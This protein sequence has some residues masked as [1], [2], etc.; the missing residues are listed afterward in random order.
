[1][2]EEVRAYSWTPSLAQERRRKPWLNI[3]LFGI[4][5]VTTTLAGALQNGAN[6]LADPLQIV[7]GLPFALTLM[8]I[9]LVHEM[10]H[11]LMARHHGVDATLP[12][13]IPAPSFIGTFGAFIKLK[14]PPLDRRSL[15]D[16]GAA[17]PLAGLVLAIPAVIIGL[18]L[19]TVSI[20]SGMGG[21]ITLG[22]SILLDFLSRLTLGLLPDEANI[23]MHPI[24][25]AGWIGLFIT[26]LNLIPV[27]QLDGGHV[28]YALF[29]QRHVWVSRLSLVA[30]LALGLIRYW[31]GWLIWSVLL[32]FMGVRHPPTLDP[33][34]PL[35]LKRKLVGWFVVGVFF[36]TFIPAPFS[37]HQSKLP[38]EQIMPKPAKSPLETLE[39]KAGQ[40]ERPTH[41]ILEIQIISN[42]GFEST[43]ATKREIFHYSPLETPSALCPPQEAG[44]TLNIVI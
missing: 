41:S 35:D 22:S 43:C 9:L 33:S 39:V 30:I 38:Q 20:D 29:G 42:T 7:S 6:P 16:V 8:T 24:G 23:I 5:L 25:F 18:H 32:L 3:A 28:A 26:A 17:G 4:T 13:F 31:D 21:G 27:G 10:G 11:Y 44:F 40:T 2:K 12:Y 34:T 37:I 19:S 14:S 1:V 36:L 15:F